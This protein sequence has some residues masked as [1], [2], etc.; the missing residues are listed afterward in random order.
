MQIKKKYLMTC[1]Q[2][3]QWISA[4]RL[5][6]AKKEKCNLNKKL[7]KNISNIIKNKLYVL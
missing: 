5:I 1:S 6:W 3:I 4:L 2:F 7:Y